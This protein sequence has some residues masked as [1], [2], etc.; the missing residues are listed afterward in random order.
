MVLGVDVGPRDSS[1]SIVAVG[2]LGEEP[3]EFLQS[4]VLTNGEG[5]GWLLSALG[6]YVQRYDRPFVVVDEKHCKHLLPDMERV[7]GFDRIVTV[8]TGDIASASDFWL[9]VVHGGRLRHRGEPE[10]T[11]ALAGAGMRDIGDGWTFS[12]RKSGVDITPLV[13]QMLAVYYWH[14]AWTDTLEDGGAQGD[15]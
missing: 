15:G 3:N 7:C 4:T 8:K 10:L 13:G 14:G 9:R 2:E 1:A 5:T 11:A 12:R 6:D